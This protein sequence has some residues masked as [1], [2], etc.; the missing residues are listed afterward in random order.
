ME[1][2]N[3]LKRVL[4]VDDVELNRFILKGILCADFEVVE[5]DSGRAALDILRKDNSDIAIVLLDIV[6]PDMDGFQVLEAMKKQGYLNYLPVIIISTESTA[7]YVDKAYDLGA[8]DFI[9]KPYNPNVVLHRVLNTIKLFNRQHTLMEIVNEQVYEKHRYADMMV[10]ILSTVM[11][12]KNGESGLH[13]LHINTITRILTET[14]LQM[15]DKY[16]FTKSDIQLICVASSL[17]DIGKMAIP[18]EIINKP[19]K[20]TPEEFDIMKTHSAK[21]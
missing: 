8:T 10:N 15:T 18:D 6:M 16:T 5:A 1:K 14:L 2:E 9:N 20:L 11:E 4:I 3:A 12:M 21:G 13:I 19:G 7:H 17:H